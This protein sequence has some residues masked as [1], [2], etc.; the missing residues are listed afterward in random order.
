ML[1]VLGSGFYTTFTS[2]Q[3]QKYDIANW[4]VGCVS[5]AYFSGLVISAFRSQHFIF[6]VGHIRA[7]AAFAALIAV[8][9]LIQGLIFSP[10]LWI[11]IRFISGYCLA[12]LCIVIES[13]LL[14]GS[15]SDNRGTILAIYMV[16]YYLAQ[17]FGQLLMKIPYAYDLMAYCIIA[18]CSAL[19]VLPVAMTHFRAPSPED[20]SIL[21]FKYLFKKAP[22]G[23][24]GSVLAGMM[25]GPLYTLI[26]VYLQQ[27]AKPENEV[28]WVMMAMILGGTL[29]QYPIGRM[30]DTVDRRKVMLGMS[31]VCIIA[32]T[33]FIPDIY[34][35]PWLM[36]LGIFMGAGA[37]I[38]YPLSTSY[39]IDQVAP[40][41]MVSAISTLLLSY[42]VGSTLGP[43]LPSILMD[44]LGPNGLCY[45]LLGIS[46]ILSIWIFYCIMVGP[47]YKEEDSTHFVSFPRT[48]PNAL[49]SEEQIETEND[50]GEAAEVKSTT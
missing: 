7:F 13:W 48:T 18:I 27:N 36:I 37:F 21:S 46:V 43:L 50:L 25:L 38:I 17:A 10:T 4:L 47:K 34:S 23:V 5:S 8:T 29:L 22:L 12:G 49:P 2:I 31:V 11:V 42:G 45:Y 6:R 14:A 33:L 41:E 39:T 40:N 35:T 19:S 32:F 15:Q 44:W 9:T 30:S 28:A 1:L 26:P 3:L 24:M 20:P 16:A